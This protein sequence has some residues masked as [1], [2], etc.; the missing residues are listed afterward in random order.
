MLKEKLLKLQVFLYLQK[1]EQYTYPE[2][3]S[4][5]TMLKG[6]NILL[7]ATIRENEIVEPTVSLY[8]FSS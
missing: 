1:T 2:S 3:Q 6:S 5:N 4:L 8:A 7:V